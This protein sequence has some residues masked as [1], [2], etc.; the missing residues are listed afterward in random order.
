MK[1]IIYSALPG[2][3]EALLC[4]VLKEIPLR[5][6]QEHVK[7]RGKSF[8]TVFRHLGQ[9]LP[10]NFQLEL[11]QKSGSK[12]IGWVCS[13]LPYQPCRCESTIAGGH[14]QAQISKEA[15]RE[16]TAFPSVAAKKRASSFWMPAPIHHGFLAPANELIIG[17]QL[18]SG[19][20]AL[21]STSWFLCERGESSPFEAGMILFPVSWRTAQ[22][23]GD[24]GKET[25]LQSEEGRQQLP[26]VQTPSHQLAHHWTINTTFIPLEQRI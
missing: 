14:F 19:P 10:R 16:H 5:Q 25:C 20:R 11:L 1:V 26:H 3:M 12:D 8:A 15:P 4:F 9:N 6:G 2:M 17:Q 13:L 18:I 7:K 23:A 22:T 21:P 24:T